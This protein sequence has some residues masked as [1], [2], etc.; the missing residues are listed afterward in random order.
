MSEHAQNPGTLPAPDAATATAEPEE[1]RR[2]R[3][4][5]ELYFLS[6]QNGNNIF[7]YIDQLTDTGNAER[8]AI[9]RGQE[10]CFCDPWN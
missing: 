10:V 5:Q 2:A 6:R 9:M 4:R 8:F 3:A 7:K 1:D